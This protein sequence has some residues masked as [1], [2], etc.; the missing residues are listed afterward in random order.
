[1][2]DN[3]VT[4]TGN[5]D[6]GT[7]T[8][9]YPHWPSH[10]HLLYRRPPHPGPTAKATDPRSWAEFPQLSTSTSMSPLGTLTAP[11]PRRR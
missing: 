9:L 1:M 4:I 5:V 3:T 2:T 10:R 11:T 6:P 7:R 8:P